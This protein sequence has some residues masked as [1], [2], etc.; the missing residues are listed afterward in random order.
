MVHPS[1][2]AGRD[3]SDRTSEARSCQGFDPINESFVIAAGGRGWT[4]AHVGDA[5]VPERHQ[6]LRGREAARRKDSLADLPELFNEALPRFLTEFCFGDFYARDGLTLAQR[7]LLVLCALATIGDTA[8]QLA[9]TAAPAS[10]GATPK[11]SSSPRLCTASPT[12][13]SRAP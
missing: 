7:E 12:S 13:G 5:A 8:A 2:T 9:P 6:V 4:H 1:G 3:K 11:R 10:R